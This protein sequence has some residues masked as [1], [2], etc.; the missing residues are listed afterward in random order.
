[1]NPFEFAI[2]WEV[3][4]PSIPPGDTA[5]QIKIP[6][7]FHYKRYSEAKCD[8]LEFAECDDSKS[9]SI[10]LIHAAFQLADKF[11]HRPW[12][13]PDRAEFAKMLAGSCGEGLCAAQK[14]V[15][16]AYAHTCA[17]EFQPL[18]AFV[19]GVVGQEVIKAISG[20][21]T[22]IQQW[23]YADMRE[24]IPG[25][26]EQVSAEGVNPEDNLECCI[27]RCAA[28]KVRNAKLFMV[29]AGA[30]A[31]ELIKNFA[32]NGFAT[33]ESGNLVLT[34]PDLI[35]KSN[36]NRQFLFRTEDIRVKSR[37]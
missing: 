17:C 18:S 16:D 24:V 11:E 35:E 3:P 23:L 10:P 30:I 13:E 1:M 14:A 8:T 26:C 19:G 12:N 9:E 5:D 37:T 36:L 20:K 6:Q 22:P 29:C 28:E 27:G 4:L 2:D 25:D 34:D 21:F 33:G 7:T 32:L 31:C 15:V